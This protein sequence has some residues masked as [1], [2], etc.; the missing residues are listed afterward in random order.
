MHCAQILGAASHCCFGQS[1]QTN[2]I[3]SG[4]WNNASKNAEIFQRLYP[5]PYRLREITSAS[6]GVICKTA[7]EISVTVL[8]KLL[9]GEGLDLE[10]A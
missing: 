3:S 5:E 8:R 4:K 9:S 2:K 1:P 6:Y 10:L 7:T